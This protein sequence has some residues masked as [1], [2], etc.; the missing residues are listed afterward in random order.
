MPPREGSRIQCTDGRRV[1]PIRGPGALPRPPCAASR[2][3]GG[4]ERLG[5][6]RRRRI[7]LVAYGARLESVLGATPRGFESR[8][9][10]PPDQRVC[11]L[12]HAQPAP[13]QAVSL[14]SGS[15]V[16]C[17]SGAGPVLRLE[18]AAVQSCC[19]LGGRSRVR[20]VTST[21]ASR[22]TLTQKSTARTPVRSNGAA[23]SS[24]WVRLTVTSVK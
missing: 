14:N 16:T 24:A 22:T 10:R 9:L 20:V 21:P 8:I 18:A 1:S 2:D 3:F 19:G 5:Y 6:P 11:R 23:P 12:G 7:R 15:G 17:E 4:G 13:A